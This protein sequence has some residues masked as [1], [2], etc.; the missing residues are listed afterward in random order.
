MSQVE[1]PVRHAPWWQ[2]KA[3]RKWI[4]FLQVHYLA[5]DDPWWHTNRNT[6]RVH[7][8]RQAF[9]LFRNTVNA[10]PYPTLKA[11]LGDVCAKVQRHLD[12]LDAK[13]PIWLRIVWHIT[14]PVIVGWT[15]WVAITLNEWAQFL[16]Q[17]AVLIFTQIL[18]AALVR[19]V[20][21]TNL[22]NF[23]LW[24]DRLVGDLP[25]LGFYTV[26]TKR[27]GLHKNYR[28]VIIMGVITGI[29]LLAVS[30]AHD[31]WSRVLLFRSSLRSGRVHLPGEAR[32][33]L[34]RARDNL[35]EKT[36]ALQRHVELADIS[37][38]FQDQLLLLKRDTHYLLAT[39]DCYLPVSDRRERPTYP[40]KPKILP[41]ILTDIIQGLTLYAA[42]GQPWYL[43]YNGGWAL[44]MIVRMVLN[45]RG[46]VSQ[47]DVNRMFTSIVA[48]SAMLM[49]LTL[50]LLFGGA[51]V[52]EPLWVKL[53]LGFVLTILVTCF[54]N[55]LCTGCDALSKRLFPERSVDVVAAVSDPTWRAGAA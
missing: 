20:R 17:L 9:L 14:I 29:L 50:T 46:Y 22:I 6:G 38:G 27:R 8:F 15:L 42:S 5:N 3:A 31:L 18:S 53:V 40:L 37:S 39:T 33:D 26:A 21:A 10:S 52:L 47:K 54:S 48:G 23:K 4:T 51:A 36:D 12:N 34:V 2:S 30:L 1:A 28:L 35:W 11:D 41:F 13:A 55:I 44:W 7:E 25:T 24:E 43:S 45:F 49:P 16:S 32:T 19:N